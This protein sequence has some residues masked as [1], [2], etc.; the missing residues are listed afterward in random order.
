VK[1]DGTSTQ[2]VSSK[3]EDVETEKKTLNGFPLLEKSVT[4]QVKSADTLSFDATGA[5][6]TVGPTKSSA[7]Y[8]STDSLGDCYSRSLES[9]NR[10]LTSVKDGTGCK[11]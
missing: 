11:R 5:L 7:S 2:V 8:V 4:E 10:V 9:V 3:Q 6:T 1:A